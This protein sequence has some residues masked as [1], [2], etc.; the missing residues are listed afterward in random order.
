MNNQVTLP[1]QEEI[2]RRLSQAGISSIPDVMQDGLYP[3]IA[4]EGGKELLVEGLVYMLAQQINIF[5]SKN[6]SISFTQSILYSFIPNF[7]DALV[8]DIE[9]AESAKRYYHEM[10][11]QAT[12][13]FEQIIADELTARPENGDGIRLAAAL[14]RF[15]SHS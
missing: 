6:G 5:V 7:I 11:A 10:D 2:M 12:K 14:A 8:D 3:L 13:K 4:Q 1:S 9:L 15:F